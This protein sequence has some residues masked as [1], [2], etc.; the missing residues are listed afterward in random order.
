[1]SELLGIIAPLRKLLAY[2]EQV[3]SVNDHEVLRLEENRVYIIPDFQ[4]EIRWD[5]DSV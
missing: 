2:N 4:R 5:E 3:I 1:M